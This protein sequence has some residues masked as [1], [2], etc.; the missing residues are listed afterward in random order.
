M[1][2]EYKQEYLGYYELSDGF[3]IDRLNAEGTEGWEVV[4]IKHPNI[5]FKR[6]KKESIPQTETGNN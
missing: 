3:N 2:Y 5:L 1:E 4:Y 6:A